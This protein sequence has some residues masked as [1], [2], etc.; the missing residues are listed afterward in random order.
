ML[1]LF[2]QIKNMNFTYKILIEKNAR[3]GKEKYEGCGHGC[4]HHYP[5]T[6]ILTN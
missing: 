5:T 2:P 3:L 4:Y 6:I 1:M